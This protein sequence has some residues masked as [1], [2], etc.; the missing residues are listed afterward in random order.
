MIYKNTKTG[1]MMISSCI[2]RGGDW[3]EVKNDQALN[4]KQEDQV[5]DEIVENQQDNV[6]EPEIDQEVQQEEQVEQETAAA[7]PG[8]IT[9]AEIMQELD[10]FGIEY[11]PRAKKQE[12]YD[13]MIAQGK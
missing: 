8:E 4:E 9:K 1:A 7:I 3:V 10:A 11:N 2:V 12:L 5:Q 13:L 6:Q